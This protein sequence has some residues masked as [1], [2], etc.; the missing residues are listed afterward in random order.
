M[1]GNTRNGRECVVSVS[2]LVMMKGAS[3]CVYSSCLQRARREWNK[4]W[5]EVVEKNHHKALDQQGDGIKVIEKKALSSKSKNN[6]S[7]G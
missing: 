2:V 1:A 3:V 5:R 7:Y 6:H 4:V